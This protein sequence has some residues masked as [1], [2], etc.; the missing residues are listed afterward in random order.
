MCDAFLHRACVVPVIIGYY[1][2]HLWS[3]KQKPAL[4]PYT[5]YATVKARELRIAIVGPTPGTMGDSKQR[6]NLG[7]NGVSCC[8]PFLVHDRLTDQTEHESAWNTSRYNRSVTHTHAHVM[9]TNASNKHTHIH[10][11]IYI[12]TH[13][14]SDSQNRNHST[15]SLMCA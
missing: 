10:I 4:F 1:Q 9:A 8:G 6:W 5:V 7:F 15:Y 14:W 2:K 13:T 11:Y 12:Y 3:M